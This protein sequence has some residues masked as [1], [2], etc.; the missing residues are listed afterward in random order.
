[1]GQSAAVRISR[2]NRSVP[3]A[4]AT[5]L[6]RTLRATMRTVANVAGEIHDSHAAAPDLAVDF[7]IGQDRV[8]LRRVRSCRHRPDRIAGGLPTD[9][10]PDHEN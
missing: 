6:S 3:S 5:S 7:D 9:V 10:P 1:M 2:R 4:S 8:D